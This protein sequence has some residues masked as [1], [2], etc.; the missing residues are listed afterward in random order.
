MEEARRMQRVPGEG[1]VGFVGRSRVVV[2][3]K[4]LLHRYHL[5]VPPAL[6]LRAEQLE[7]RGH[8]VVY[9]TAGRRVAG[10]L[11]LRDD[12][13]AEVKAL[14]AELRRAGVR[15]VLVTGDN[16][17][18]AQALARRAGISEV[19]WRVSARGK[20]R[21]LRLAREQGKIA[22]FVGDAVEDVYPL[23]VADVGIVLHGKGRPVHR[24]G[25]LLLLGRHL[26]RVAHALSWARRGSVEM[27]SWLALALVFHFL[28]ALGIILCVAWGALAALLAVLVFGEGAAW[29]LPWYARRL[30]LV[31]LGGR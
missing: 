27:H 23:S 2:G 16:P 9:V 6:R 8:S 17:R 13:R 14:M 21:L 5:D 29:L 4:S 18:T 11:A 12:L 26:Q 20:A 10:L 1:V 25:D 3:T 28:V 31:V 19:H 22:A 7:D 30:S 24:V 15:V